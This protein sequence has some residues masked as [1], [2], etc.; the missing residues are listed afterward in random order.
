M[1]SNLKDEVQR[2]AE[3]NTIVAGFNIFGS[4]DAQGVI[5]AAEK[6]NAPVFLMINKDALEAMPMQSWVDMLKPMIDGCKVK[7][8]VHLDHCSDVD[9]VIS[10]IK[11][12]FSS[13]MY[14]GSQLPLEKNIQNIQQVAAVARAYDV[15]L[16]GEIGS[17]PYADIPG[18][19]KDIYTSPEDLTRFAGEGN[20]DWIAIAIGQVHRLRSCVAQVNFE[21]LARLQGCTNKPLVIHGGSGIAPEDIIKMRSSRIGK[22]NIGTALRIPFFKALQVELKENPTVYD[23]G[24]LFKKSIS[25]VESA[26]EEILS[27]L[28]Y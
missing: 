19:A 10:G 4:E 3:G 21:S 24:I 6:C 5:A 22:I 20:M 11:A 14:D 8:G 2:A 9:K 18:R 13:V 1:I 12:G 28:G 23:R 15:T 27:I 17:V 26:A 7:I 16:E 25:A